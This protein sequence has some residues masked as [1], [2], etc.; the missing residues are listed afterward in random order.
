MRRYFLDTN[1][2]VLWVV[3]NSHPDWLGQKKPVT[4]LDSIDFDNLSA[5]I[6]DARGFLTLPYV[7]AE[8][9][10]LLGFGKRNTATEAIYAQFLKYVEASEELQVNSRILVSDYALRKTGLTDLAI[11]RLVRS[12]AVVVTTDFALFGLLTDISVEAKNLRHMRSI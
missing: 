4:D 8:A 11:L 9:S 10:N 12:Q 6:A 3:G 7:L 5:L 1:S 2:L